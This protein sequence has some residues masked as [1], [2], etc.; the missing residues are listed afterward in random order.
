MTKVGNGYKWHDTKPLRGLQRINK[1]LNFVDDYNG[2]LYA[3]NVP[4]TKI[5]QEHFKR[6]KG[7]KRWVAGFAISGIVCGLAIIIMGVMFTNYIPSNL[8]RDTNLR[9]HKAHGL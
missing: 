2:K 3:T 9:S 8:K 5:P 7:Q 1:T 4:D 6:R